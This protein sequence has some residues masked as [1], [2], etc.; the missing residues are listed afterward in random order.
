M[1]KFD[2]NYR[3]NFKTGDKVLV[4]SG[5]ASSGNF[6][7]EFVEFSSYKDETK[8]YFFCSKEKCWTVDDIMPFIEI[9]DD[10]EINK[11][12]KS[13][14][15]WFYN[16]GDFK[17]EFKRKENNDSI[18]YVIYSDFIKT[19]NRMC[20]DTPYLLDIF[21]KCMKNFDSYNKEM[22]IYYSRTNLNDET[23]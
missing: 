8:K 19:F 13:M 17:S 23:Y 9:E 11:C 4:E 2:K 1:K 21:K 7:G 16:S 14:P 15:C 22:V 5:Y 10:K 18:K 3:L 6:N 20:I 12:L